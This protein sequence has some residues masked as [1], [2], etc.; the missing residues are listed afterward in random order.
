MYYPNP[1]SILEG[2]MTSTS[3]PRSRKR[4]AGSPSSKTRNTGPTTTSRS[5][6]PYSR[7]FQQNLTDHGIYPPE[8]RHPN[9]EKMLRPNNWDEIKER[10]RNPR[11][12]LSPSRFSEKELEEFREADAYASKEKPVTTTVIPIIEGDICDSK[13]TGGG[14]LFGNLAHLTDGTLAQ[15]KP[16]HFYGARPEQLN[17]QIRKELSN[18]IIP[19]TQDDLPMVPNFF[20]E[21]KGP[22]GSLAVAMRQ[23]CYDGAI[24]ARGMQSLQS[25]RQDKLTYDNNAYT[26]TSIYHG[27]TLKLYTAHI[28]EPRG[29]GCRP[30]YIMSQLNGWAMTGDAETFRQ[31][32]SA[33][34][35]ARDWAKEMRD[36]FITAAN[37]HLSDAQLQNQTA[38]SVAVSDALTVPDETEYQDAQWSFAAPLEGGEEEFQPLMITSFID[39]AGLMKRMKAS[40][41]LLTHEITSDFENSLLLGPPIVQGQYEQSI[42]QFRGAYELGDQIARETLKDI[43]ISLQL[44]VLATLRMALLDSISPDFASLQVASD[45]ARVETLMCLYKLAQRI[46][47]SPPRYS[48]EHSLIPKQPAC[49]STPDNARQNLSHSPLSHDASSF[50]MRANLVSPSEAPFL[51]PLSSL[52]PPSVDSAFTE[53]AG[54]ASLDHSVGSFFGGRRFPYSPVSHSS[55]QPRQEGSI[56][57][58]RRVTNRP[59]SVYSESIYSEMSSHPIVPTE[60]TNE[61][62]ISSL[63]VS[64][65]QTSHKDKSEPPKEQSTSSNRSGSLLSGFQDRRKRISISSGEK[66]VPRSG[67]HSVLGFGEKPHSVQN[68]SENGAQSERNLAYSQTGSPIPGALY[69]PCEENKFAGFCKGA[70]KLQNAMKKSFRLDFRR[71]T[72][73]LQIST[74]RCTKCCFEGPMGHSP[75]AARG[76][77][78]SPAQGFARTTPLTG[79]SSKDFDQSVRLHSSSGVRYRWAFLAKSHIPI[80]STLKRTD[81]TGGSFGCIYC[82][83]EQQGPAPVFADIDTFMEH[84]KLHGGAA[85]GTTEAQAKRVP[86]QDLLNWTKCIIGRVAPEDEGFDLNIPKIVVEIGI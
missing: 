73:Y 16:D 64:S 53:D 32:A 80:R 7:N 61:S 62:D 27:G 1:G 6:T 44:T 41:N 68:N 58:K 4:P 35:N 10:L 55:R 75:A 38:S 81:G 17:R 79:S 85:G 39:A 33:Y 14:Y 45:N 51:A 21:A 34:R 66:P 19:S 72:T 67:F 76:S 5:S 18:Q 8:Y 12:S 23:A 83:A 59:D 86:S 57:T 65:R 56:P 49:S 52:S 15:A 26:I 82:C 46:G 20:L 47:M 74:W 70:W 50:D 37:E 31:G 84:L 22:D 11:Q 29:P 60:T 40:E 63:G 43:V 9:G 78:S 2:P 54:K 25:Y 69:L 36:K 30:G 48:P 28:S 24:G 3:T 13:C 71:T 42:R 77:S